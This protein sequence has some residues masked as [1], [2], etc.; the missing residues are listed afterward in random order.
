MLGK[1]QGD[2]HGLGSVVVGQDSLVVG[3][4]ACA[5]TYHSLQDTQTAPFGN[6]V[7]TVL[8]ASLV[9]LLGLL[10]SCFQ[11]G[12]DFAHTLEQQLGNLLQFHDGN[13][14]NLPFLEQF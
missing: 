13:V 14:A 11:F 7:Q 2:E 8:V 3:I 1:L 9:F 5:G 4:A 12:T 10:D 6:V